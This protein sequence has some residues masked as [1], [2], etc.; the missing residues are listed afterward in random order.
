M[1]LV[2]D[3]L[4]A[5]FAIFGFVVIFISMRS[6]VFFPRIGDPIKRKEDPY[7]FFLFMFIL[8]AGSCL[9]LWI[10]LPDVIK[11]FKRL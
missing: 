9:G 7:K 5:A 1:N 4:M 6:G 10:A 8:F 2:H 3:A 11:G